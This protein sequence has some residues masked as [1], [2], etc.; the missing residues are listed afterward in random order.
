MQGA[1]RTLFTST[2]PVERLP[3][4][5]LARWAEIIAS[6]LRPGGFFYIAEFHPVAHPHSP[7]KS[8]HCSTHSRLVR[9]KGGSKGDRR[10]SWG[11]RA[12]PL[13]TDDFNRCSVADT[14]VPRSGR[15][16]LWRRPG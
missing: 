10:P 7:K 15:C 11:L 3:P 1:I 4:P 16:V 12:T 6:F 2:R 14:E 5:D 8:I 9:E 13:P